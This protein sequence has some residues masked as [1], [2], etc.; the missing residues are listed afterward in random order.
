MESIVVIDK[1]EYEELVRDSEKLRCIE[2]LVMDPDVHQIIKR[3]HH[4]D[5]SLH[6]A[7]RLNRRGICGICP[8]VFDSLATGMDY[9]QGREIHK[10]ETQW[11]EKTGSASQMQTLCVK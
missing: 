11:Q 10:K 9:R 8:D 2:T 4:N 3:Q 7:W 5:Y 1:N 6:I